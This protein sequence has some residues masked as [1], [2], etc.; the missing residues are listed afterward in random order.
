MHE[1]L[2]Q[3]DPARRVRTGERPLEVAVLLPCYNEALV[4]GTVLERFRAA[5]QT[6]ESMSTTTIARIVRLKSPEAP[7]RSFAT[8]SGR[9][10]VSWCAGCSPTSTPISMSCVMQMGPMTHRSHLNRGHALPAPASA[11]PGRK[12]TESRSP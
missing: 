2:E 7:V 1:T 4:I 8:K 10:R 6:S 5:V 3:I 11:C 12:I 9:A